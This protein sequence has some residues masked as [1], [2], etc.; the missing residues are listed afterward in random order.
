MTT[1]WDLVKRGLTMWKKWYIAGIASIGMKKLDG[2]ITIHT[3]WTMQENSVISGKVQ[4]GKCLTRIITAR[5]ERGEAMA[6]Y[7]EREAL[8][9]LLEERIEYLFKENGD[10]DHHTNG[11][12]EA[13]GKVEDFPVAADAVEV[14]RCKDCKHENVNHAISDKNTWCDYWG[15]DPCFDDFCSYGERRDNDADN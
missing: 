11:F 3:S 12:D 2:A 4:T 13:V 10:Y 8:M 1:A 9:A 6:E 5:T 7:I 15:I 14:V